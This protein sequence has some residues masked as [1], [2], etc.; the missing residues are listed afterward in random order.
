MYL[1]SRQDRWAT[2]ASIVVVV[3]FVYFL[4]RFA[5]QDIIPRESFTIAY[6]IVAASIAG[7]LFLRIGPKPSCGAF[8]LYAFYLLFRFA[9]Q[10]THSDLA[11]TSLFQY[12]VPLTFF[13][14]GYY[15]WTY[16]NFNAVVNVF[17]VCTFISLA[18][19]LG[20]YYFGIGERYFQKLSL[21]IVGTG[22]EI[23]SRSY[24]LAGY[25]LGTGFLAMTGIILT[26]QRPRWQQ[27]VL[28]PLLSLTL[29]NSFS[30]GALVMLLTGIG[31]WAAQT[32]KITRR[33]R[34][35]NSSKRPHLLRALIVIGIL[36]ALLIVG[37]VA[38]SVISSRFL[39]AYLF[40]FVFNMVDLGEE[41]NALRIIAWQYAV[42]I[43]QTN[44]LLGAGFGTLGSSVATQDPSVLAPESMYLKLLGELGVTG[45]LLY[46]STVIPP[47]V[48]TVKQMLRQ[49][50]EYFNNAIGIN[51]SLVGAILVGGLFLQ[52]LESDFL[53][54]LFW[55]ILGGIYAFGD[56][57][58]AGEQQGIRQLT[59]ANSKRGQGV[60]RREGI[61]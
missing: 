4:F 24:S 25:S 61:R 13:V 10:E 57:L 40:R 47:L 14:I 44:P 43:W 52:N 15:I 53:A 60:G 27:I 19:G 1:T 58:K 12:F 32:T 6:G 23:I 31:I 55:F 20:N 46:L 36:L 8:Y 9:M 3:V 39:D 21:E 16:G 17:L 37:I 48:H 35:T 56:G 33:Q 26:I 7:V 34:V 50:R 5:V 49:N 22:N 11:L 28:L 18:A 38:T 42:Q 51:V 45:L 30:R 59:A 29:L 41:G 54:A 2:I